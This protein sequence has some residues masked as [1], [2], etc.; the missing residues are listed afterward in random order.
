MFGVKTL[1]EKLNTAINSGS[2][3]ELQLAQAFGAIDSLESHGVNSV[4]TEADLPN[5]V[6][7][8]GRF[9]WINSQ[10]RYVL[11]DGSSWNINRVIKNIV[12]LYTWGGNASYGTLGHNNSNIEQISPVPIAGSFTDWVQASVAPE[13]TGGGNFILGVRANGT[14]WSWGRG[15]VGVLGDGTTVNRSSPVSVIGG[16]TDW[17]QASAGRNHSLGLRANGTLY[18][19]GSNSFGQLGQN[20][21]TSTS[22]SS[23]VLV[24]GGITD[25]KQVS[26]NGYQ[27]L[28]L[29]A[30]GQLYSWGR[31]NAGQ[32]GQNIVTTTSRSSPVL[33]A[34]GYVNWIQAS[35]GDQHS[36][37]IRATGQLYSWGSNASG[38]LGQ[39][40]ITTTN[41]SSPV[42]V[43]GGITDWTQA[44]AGNN[45]SLGIRATGQLYTWGESSQGALGTGDVSNRSSPVLVVGGFTDWV[46]VEAGRST[47]NFSMGIRANGTLWA[48]GWNSAANL[49]DN[50][51]VNK[52]SPVSVAG[53]FTDW[54]S[55]SVGVTSV[56]IRG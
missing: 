28:G 22:R 20:I 45:I 18:S 35:A 43:A 12:N 24:A 11:S 49:G 16:I 26:A 39:N 6:L 17:V 55:L 31:N 53:G 33:V 34:G 36:L 41:R 29:R 25:W 46:H 3:T 9:F 32:L 2:L 40:I 1:I 4:E 54:V 5:V 47:N 23:P 10:N 14:I 38:E 51:R 52:S 7:N 30:T 56:G 42:L 13:S 37:A 19:W 50:T 44:S 21:I 8:K 48:W 15:T 27:A